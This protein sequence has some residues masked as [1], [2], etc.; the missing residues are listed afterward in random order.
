MVLSGKT[1]QMRLSTL[2]KATEVQLETDN[3]Q[4][5]HIDGEYKGIV[6]KVDLKMIPS[7]IQI[8]H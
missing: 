5:F 8:I 1:L 2:I 3:E 6:K 4:H 7:A